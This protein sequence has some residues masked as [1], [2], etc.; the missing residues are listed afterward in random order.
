MTQRGVQYYWGTGRRKTSIARV[1]LR[2]GRGEIIINDRPADEYFPRPPLRNM[3]RQPLIVTSTLGKF[4]V[5][6]NVG[7]GGVSGQAGAVRH[8]IS[9]ALLELDPNLRPTLKRE[10]LLTRDPRMVERKKY[11]KRGARRSFQFSKR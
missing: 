5:L 3:I 2:A 6:V 8:G 7:G 1:R 9:R 10:G 4:D 11:G